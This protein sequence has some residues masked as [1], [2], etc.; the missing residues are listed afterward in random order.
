METDITR[1]QNK[2]NQNNNFSAIPPMQLTDA[3]DT[4]RSMLDDL[5]MRDQRMTLCVM[6][7]VHVA[8]S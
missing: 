1:W 4:M 5:T 3:R 6:T 7:L 2:Q 8:D